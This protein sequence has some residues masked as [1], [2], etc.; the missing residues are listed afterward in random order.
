MSWRS[1]LSLLVILFCWQASPATGAGGAP[2]RI[3]L[4]IGNGGYQYAPVLPNAVNDGRDMA[5]KLR[6]LDFEVYEGID[7]DRAGML[8]LLENFV[9]RLT[10]GEVGLFFYSGHAVE[11]DRVNYLMPV[12]VEARTA[13]TSRAPSSTS[14]KSSTGWRKRA[15]PRS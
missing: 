3:A 4:V 5:E 1:A 10:G 11:L 2:A 9:A 6:S 14:R 12:D 15:R 7:L 8:A 13:A